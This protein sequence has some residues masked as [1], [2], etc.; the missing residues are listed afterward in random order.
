MQLYEGYSR[1]CHAITRRGVPARDYIADLSRTLTRGFDVD[2]GADGDAL[3]AAGTRIMLPSHKLAVGFAN[4]WAAISA[5]KFLA[6]KAADIAAAFA[7]LPAA[8]RPRGVMFW[9][10]DEEGEPA[11]FA[12][13]LTDAFLMMAQTDEGGGV[14]AAEW[15][16]S[17]DSEGGGAPPAAEGEG[18]STPLLALP[19]AL[20]GDGGSA[21]RTLSVGGEGVALDHLGPMVVNKDGTLSQIANWGAMSEREQEVTRRRIGKRNR[22]R[23]AK[24][25]A[26]EKS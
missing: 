23:L 9:V 26:A 18:P 1:A 3:G 4:S 6:V 15:C 24:L 10:I 16:P 17:M 21:A 19:P 11:Y 22:E 2:F 20:D 7:A 12:K 5:G 25:K 13:E 14:P 8:N